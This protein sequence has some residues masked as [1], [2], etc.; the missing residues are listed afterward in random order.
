MTNPYEIAQRIDTT[1]ARIDELVPEIRAAAMEAA[2]NETAFKM[3]FAQERLKARADFAERGV[4]FTTD[5]VEDVATVATAS[6]R[7]TAMYATNNL[8]VLREVLRAE[9]SKLDG[10]RTISASVRVAGG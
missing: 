6:L 10:L 3:A 8:M 5:A 9:E 4:K 1:L 2:V 7:Q